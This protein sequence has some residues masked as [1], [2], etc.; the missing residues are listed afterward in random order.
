M[1]AKFNS[2]V[3]LYVVLKVGAGWPYKSEN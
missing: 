3:I 2:R 1:M